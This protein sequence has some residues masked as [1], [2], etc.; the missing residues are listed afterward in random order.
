LTFLG[1]ERLGHVIH[2]AGVERPQQHVAVLRGGDEHHRRDRRSRRLQRLDHIEPVHARHDHVEQD[3]V[4]R[5]LAI[6]GQCFIAVVGEYHLV[7]LARQQA[8][9]DTQV[10]RLVVDDQ[11][12]SIGRDVAHRKR[13]TATPVGP[14]PPKYQNGRSAETG[15]AMYLNQTES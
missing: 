7:A 14:G 5:G 12:P 3:E 15:P 8:A 6:T 2:H 9:D 11:D 1:Q 4:G 10:H 13:R